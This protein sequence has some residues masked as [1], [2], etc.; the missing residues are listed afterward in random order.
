MYL[1]R[2]V[3]WTT[4]LAII[5]TASI[6]PLN[7]IFKEENIDTNAFSDCDCDDDDDVIGIFERLFLGT[8]DSAL[9]EEVVKE[10]EERDR[11][12]DEFELGILDLF[13]N[14]EFR[15]GLLSN[16]EKFEF[17]LGLGVELLLPP[18][19]LPELRVL[20]LLLLVL[21]CACLSLVFACVILAVDTE[22]E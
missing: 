11:G 9:E 7:P 15:I 16:N 20:S 8:D 21:M 13:L 12:P 2:G 3:S 19:P 10:V 6:I 18:L 4:L 22:T 1:P 17:E 14:I 5:S